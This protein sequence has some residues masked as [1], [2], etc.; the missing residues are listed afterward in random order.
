MTWMRR[1][2][3]LAIWAGAVVCVALATWYLVGPLPSREIDADVLVSNPDYY[4]YLIQAPTI[5][6]D[7]ARV[8]GWGA[9]AVVL[10]GIVGFV[11]RLR[12]GLDRRWIGPVLLLALAGAVIGVGS[13]VV[14]APVIGAN[15]GGGIA[16]LFGVPFVVSLAA[17]A[18]WGACSIHRSPTLS[19]N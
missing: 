15:I 12:S 18:A 5:D 8:V 7:V 9:V 16:I 11:L 1:T 17:R 4:D 10:A 6:P 19:G 14:T 13:C 3:Q 2:G